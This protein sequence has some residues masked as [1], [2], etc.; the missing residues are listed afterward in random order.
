MIAAR[1]FRKPFPSVFSPISLIAPAH[2]TIHRA[3][4]TGGFTESIEMLNHGD[5]MRQAAI[6]TSKTHGAHAANC[7]RKVGRSHFH[8]DVSPIQSELRKRGFDHG[9]GRISRRAL[10]HTADKFRKEAL[11]S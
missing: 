10:R 9:D 8:I 1:D 4:E 2:D 3:H 11:G 5:L 6:E 7:V